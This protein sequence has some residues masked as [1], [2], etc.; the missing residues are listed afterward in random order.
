MQKA[1]QNEKAQK[2]KPN[3]KEDKTPEKQLSELEISNL[4]EKTLE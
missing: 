3:E 4:Y 2:Y 1:I